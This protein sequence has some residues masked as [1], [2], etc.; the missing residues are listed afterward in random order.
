MEQDQKDPGALNI[1][2]I[3]FDLGGV[4]VHLQP[5]EWLLESSQYPD[6][7]LAARWSASPALAA[8]ESGRATPVEFA[9]GLVTDLRLACDASVFLKRF[10]EWPEPPD[11]EAVALL[12]ALSAALPIACLSNTND[13]HWSRFE[14][15]GSFL[16]LFRWLFPSHQTLKIKPNPDAFDHALRVMGIPAQRIL[17]LDDSTGN[18]AAARDCG[19]NACQALGTGGVRD[20]LA[21]YGLSHAAG[22]KK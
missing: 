18:V 2:A 17:F 11:A 8:F 5:F 20:A 7:E 13:L 12:T 22:G 15:D 9:D 10:I 3:L 16:H 21:R 4:L 6:T 1:E 14:A 19:L